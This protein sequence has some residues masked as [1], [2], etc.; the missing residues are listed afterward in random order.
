MSQSTRRA[1]A[2]LTALSFAL[3][4]VLPPIA[5]AHDFTLSPGGTTTA[6]P[7]PPGGGQPPA[8]NPS[9]QDEGVQEILEEFIKCA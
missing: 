7:P 4:V 2:V 1:V 3:Q 6:Q 8:T 9:H 5:L